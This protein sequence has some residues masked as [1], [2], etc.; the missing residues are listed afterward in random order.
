M[1]LSSAKGTAD[2]FIH[3][4]PDAIGSAF[5]GRVFAK[6]KSTG[7]SL[8]L[9]KCDEAKVDDA[10]VLSFGKT[11]LIVVKY[12]YST[13]T[14][15]DDEVTLYAYET[16][17]PSTEP[18][19]PLVTI[20]PTGS[21]TSS[22]PTDIG[23]VA[24]RQG[25]NTP[26][27]YV[28]GIRVATNWSLSPLPVEMNS[29]YV[30]ANRLSAELHWSTATEVDNYGFEIER[31]SSNPVWIKIGFVP[32]SGTSNSLHT[33]TYSNNVGQ[34]GLY[35]YRIKQID[36]TGTFKYST[37]M[38]IE[39]GSGPKVLSLGSNYPNPF[40]PSTSIEFSVPIDGRA[41]MK[42]YN[43]LGQE[44]AT[45][46]DGEATAGKLMKATF[47]GSRL[48]SGVYFSRLETCDKALVKRMVLMK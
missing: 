31:K 24:I 16:G 29:F 9:S 28:D 15:S 7:W 36:K 46:F 41:A 12:S 6:S 48:S 22:D 4:G 33:Y 5:R 17:V 35:E 38:Q 23:S 42:I 13:I 3:L 34:A 20:G 45:L 21:G 18:G 37:A 14:T 27:G 11:Y 26:T 25:A 47:D 32:G 43:M 30:M 19:S 10:T 40:N 1:N 2:Y 8:G 44:V 39:V